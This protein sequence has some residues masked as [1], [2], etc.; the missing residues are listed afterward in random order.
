MG[1]HSRIDELRAQLKSAGGDVSGR[2]TR[3]SWSL[4]IFAT[5]AS[6]AFIA[7]ILAPPSTSSTSA[8]SFGTI[9]APAAVRT[10][11]LQSVIVAGEATTVASRDVFSIT[12]PVPV[13]VEPVVVE[14]SSQAS[15]GAP[16]AGVPDP[17]SAQAIAQS[18]LQSMGMGDDQYSCLVALW[19]RESGWN[20]YAYNA[21]SGAYGIPQSLPGDKMASAGADWATNPAT[22][23]SWGLSYITSRYG[24]PCGA[25]EHSENNG[26]Y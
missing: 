16:A 14:A 1:R 9:V 24:T 10:V 7:V 4:P 17:G 13:V 18:M 19:N 23:I 3:T 12:D 6:F 22:Q 15:S 25:W 8:A 20:I 21:S 2:H 11:E 26:W 5:L